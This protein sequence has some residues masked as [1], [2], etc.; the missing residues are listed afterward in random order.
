VDVLGAGVTFQEFNNLL[1]ECASL[2]SS[3]EK[4]HCG[5]TYKYDMD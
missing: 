4:K 1:K 5:D 2:G 3:N